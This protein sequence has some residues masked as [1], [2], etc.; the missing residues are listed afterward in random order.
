M[1]VNAYA[2]LL[3]NRFLNAFCIFPLYHSD[4]NHIF[5]FSHLL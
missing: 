4:K 1:N 5:H 3:K 2:L